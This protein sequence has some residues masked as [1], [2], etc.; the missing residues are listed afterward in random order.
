M[1]TFKFSVLI[2]CVFLSVMGFGGCSQKE[3]I[4][5]SSVEAMTLFELEQIEGVESL[6][7]E[8]IKALSVVIRTNLS[9]HEEVQNFAYIPNNKHLAELVTQTAGVT[10]NNLSDFEAVYASS[11]RTLS[12]NLFYFKGKN[13]WVVEIK[14]S[15]ILS[16]LNQNGISLSNISDFE[17][18][19][20][21]DHLLEAIR[22]GGKTI[23]YET[24][25]SEFGLKSNKIT[26]ISN[27]LTKIVVGGEYINGF[28]IDE[29][30][31][32][33][34]S[35]LNYSQIINSLIK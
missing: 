29:A 8:T 23:P 33:A 4:V 13:S 20:S 32:L 18:V 9:G 24:L 2:L 35:G 27:Q 30:E 15:H 31:T 12:E 26:T 34:Q 17:P 5:Q 3:E 19:Y 6:S 7:D 11:S 25:K 21:Q 14:K 16:Y 10:I 28:C 1:K 22:L